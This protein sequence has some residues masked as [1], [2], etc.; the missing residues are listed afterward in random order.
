[1]IAIKNMEMPSCC[2]K[3]PFNVIEKDMYGLDF[4]YCNKTD[5]MVDENEKDNDCPLVEII[6][7]KDCG[8]NDDGSCDMDGCG[9]EDDCYCYCAY[10]RKR[11]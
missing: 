5:K 11:G 2:G 6:T 9:I 8:H 7:C 1:M 4:F 10:R 3:C